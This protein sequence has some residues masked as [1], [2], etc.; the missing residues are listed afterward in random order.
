[1][2]DSVRDYRDRAPFSIQI[3]PAE[4]VRA[5]INQREKKER[6]WEPGRDPSNE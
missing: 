1:M 3:Q 5:I 2:T 6:D 4:R